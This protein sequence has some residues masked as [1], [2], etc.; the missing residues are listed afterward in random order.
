MT[1][2]EYNPHKITAKS[3]KRDK[4]G[5][6]APGNKT[7]RQE[8]S[9][10]ISSPLASTGS[11]I[12][13]TSSDPP[14]VSFS[15]TNPVTYLKI[16]WKKVIKNEGVDLRFRIRPLTAIGIALAISVVLFGGGYGYALFTLPITQK[17]N[18]YLPIPIPIP[19]PPPGVDHLRESAY[20]G[21]LRKT[22][23][24]R[25]YL[26]SGEGFAIMLSITSK[27]GNLDAFAG[28]RIFVSGIYDSTNYLFYP[29]EL[30][31]LE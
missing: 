26:Q 5:R 8:R 23:E 24:G 29:R 28:K 25:Y 20:T 21:V 14:L 6:F 3:Q 2:E 4:G 1:E 27:N 22:G 30:T 11:D 31:P 10:P 19:S 15:V 17:I 13:S 7:I 16:W 12:T 9:D 18:S